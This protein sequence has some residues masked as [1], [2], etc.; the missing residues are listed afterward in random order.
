MVVSSMF[1]MAQYVES[2]LDLKL[3]WLERYHLARLLMSALTFA[4]IYKLEKEDEDDWF[5]PYIIHSVVGHES[6]EDRPSFKTRIGKPF[7]K[8]TS[9]V[10]R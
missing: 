4:G 3:K 8:W 7:P 9:N 6:L 1:K 10:D 2:A 5:K